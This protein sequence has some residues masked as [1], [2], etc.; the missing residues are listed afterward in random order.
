MFNEYTK[1]ITFKRAS[2][3]YKIDAKVET[4]YTQEAQKIISE[5]INLLKKCGVEISQKL[6]Y[7][8]V[9]K[10][11]FNNFSFDES[12]G[13]VRKLLNKT[14]IAFKKSKDSQDN[15]DVHEFDLSDDDDYDKVFAGALTLQYDV[16][17]YVMEVNFSDLK[18]GG[19]EGM[20]QKLFNWVGKMMDKVMDS[21][22]QDSLSRLKTMTDQMGY[23]DPKKKE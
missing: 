3:E 4:F 22:P 1:T 8:T 6:D 5:L 19:I 2:Q 16:V 12:I 20:I 13:M 14:K 23:Q 11:L 18:S 7:S 9:I 10:A 17:K 21:I 15:E